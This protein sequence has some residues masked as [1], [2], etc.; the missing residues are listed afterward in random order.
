MKLTEQTSYAL[1]VFAACAEVYPQTIKVAD[2]SGQTGITE[3][4][5]FKLS[6]IASRNNLIVST[7]GPSGGIRLSGAPDTMYMGQVIRA[8]EPRFQDCGPA[9][10]IAEEVEPDQLS[11]RVGRFIGQGYGAFLRELDKVPLSALTD[12]DREA[13][14]S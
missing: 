5:I 6:K 9:G 8:F 12:A 13:N 1:R 3:F 11:G 2:I 14:A 10:M 4:N 7:R